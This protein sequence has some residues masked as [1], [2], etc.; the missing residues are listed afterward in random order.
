MGVL[1][2]R[3]ASVLKCDDDDSRLCDLPFRQ[4]TVKMLRATRWRGGQAAWAVGRRGSW[5]QAWDAFFNHEPL[6]PPPSRLELFSFDAPESV[7]DWIIL[8]DQQD[9]GQSWADWHHA[10][11]EGAGV[12]VLAGSLST[13]FD[14][15]SPEPARATPSSFAGARMIRSGYCSVRSREPAPFGPLDEFDGLAFVLRSD[16][17]PYVVTVKTSRLMQDTQEIYQAL[18]PPPPLPPGT[19][20]EAEMGAL[21]PWREVTLPWAAFVMTWRGFVQPQAISMD[22]RRVE[23]IGL[24][25]CAADPAHEDIGYAHMRGGPFTLELRS[26]STYFAGVGM[27]REE[28]RCSVQQRLIHAASLL[29]RGVPDD[30]R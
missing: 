25:L 28:A 23:S 17:R 8:T 15:E 9:G 14:S 11:R 19:R 1:G 30:G 29:A 20:S 2:V 4:A 3:A 13:E 18:L 7:K 5:S 12:G 27:A 22:P 24:S 16:H 26:V 10:E 6:R 21:G